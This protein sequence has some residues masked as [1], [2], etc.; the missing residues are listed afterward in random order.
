MQKEDMQK[1]T[2]IS[3]QGWKNCYKLSNN[4]IELI[5]TADVGPR[6]IS[7]KFN[8]STNEL[9]EYEN[10]LGQTGA[11]Q[12]M[13]YGGHRLWHAPEEKPR[14]YFPDN[15]PVKVQEFADFVR[16][17]PD[18]EASNGVQ[19]EI[20]IYLH[21]NKAQ[22]KLVHTIQNKNLWPIELAAWTLSVM[23]AGGKAIIPLPP[24][25]G[26][27]GNLL[28]TTNLALWSYTNMQDNRF[29][30]GEKYITIQQDPKA[31]TPQKIGV[32]VKQGWMAYVRENL[33]V[34]K[35]S[36]IKDSNYPDRGSNCE[37]YTDADMLELES[38]SPLTML[39]PEEKIEHVE[40]WFLFRNVQTP[41]S[42]QEIDKVILPL[43]ESC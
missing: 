26:H 2:K 17:T 16:F 34:K 4:L 15:F 28:P 14:T 31:T 23:A 43:V 13:I 21:A 27:A 9:K 40:E 3:Y 22:V 41:N 38:L 7:C 36:F 42:E 5:I 30:W 35:F 11:D 6:I 37:V 19:K 32:E 24:K 33:F 29:N 20:D 12:W 25:T 39:K 8:D 18:L 1:L 10:M